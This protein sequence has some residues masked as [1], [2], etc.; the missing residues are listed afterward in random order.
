VILE[1]L[2]EA[3][4]D[5]SRVKG[6]NAAR[7]KE[8]AAL[9]IINVEI[10]ADEIPEE[11]AAELGYS[12]KV[13]NGWIEEAKKLAGTPSKK[14][15]IER[16]EPVAKK[17]KKRK[18]KEMDLKDIL[19]KNEIRQLAKI[20]IRT[21]KDLA[22]EDPE[23]LSILLG[24]NKNITINWVNEARRLMGMETITLEKRTKKEKHEQVVEML[25]ETKDLHVEFE[26]EEQIQPEEIKE[27]IKEIEAVATKPAD[28]KE[29]LKKTTALLVKIP[30]LGKASAEK[31]FKAGIRTIEDLIHANPEELAEKSG[32]SPKKIKVFIENATN[33]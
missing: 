19:S 26:E 2:Q 8:L 3:I 17:G 20:E 31:L 13:V 32:I 15:E 18:T 12:T 23:E 33:L 27:S 25:E 7:A 28:E 11:L 14:K 16:V 30:G 9:G 5:L 1:K 29:A 6:I 10:L 22:E 4:K 24:V 21:L